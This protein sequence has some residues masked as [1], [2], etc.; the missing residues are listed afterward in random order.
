MGRPLFSSQTYHPLA[1]RIEPE[2]TQPTCERWTYWNPFD[3]DSEEFFVD[4]EEERIRPLDELVVEERDRGAIDELSSSSSEGTSSGRETPVFADD[5]PFVEELSHA[6]RVLHRSGRPAQAESR[7]IFRPVEDEGHTYRAVQARAV[8]SPAVAGYASPMATSFVRTA[9]YAEQL[10]RSPSPR[11]QP[12]ARMEVAAD[13]VA[14]SGPTPSHTAPI[15]IP[16]RPSTPPTQASWSY[17]TPSPAPSVTPRLYNWRAHALLG[18]ASP[19]SPLP[20]RNAR[21]S[22]AH[23]SPSAIAIQRVVG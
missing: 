7:R 13:P 12:L 17:G 10:S 19:A 9:N 1:V 4:A 3:P 20:N 5:G 15:A 18:V 22:V 11:R 21:M 2:P 14:I 16:A 23:I 8:Q 6:V